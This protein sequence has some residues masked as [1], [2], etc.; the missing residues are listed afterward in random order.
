ME[1]CAWLFVKIPEIG[2]YTLIIY[3]IDIYLQSKLGVKFQYCF[4]ISKPK[5]RYL[6]MMN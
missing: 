3:N 4:N 2:T 6:E 5:Q 1:T